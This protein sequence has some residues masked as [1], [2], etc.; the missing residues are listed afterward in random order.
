M[1][2]NPCNYVPQNAE[3]TLK[4]SAQPVNWDPFVNSKLSCPLASQIGFPMS[5]DFIPANSCMEGFYNTHST[6]WMPYAN[7]SAN[8]YN[9]KNIERYDNRFMNPTEYSTLERSYTLDGK[10]RC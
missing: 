5:K 7:V 6:M 9:I 8:N 1:N 2:K 10:R 3:W 4:S